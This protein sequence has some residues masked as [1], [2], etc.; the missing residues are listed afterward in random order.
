MQ[1]GDVCRGNMAGAG[2]S[3]LTWK[4]SLP[5]SWVK[6]AA[7]FMLINPP[8]GS[9]VLMCCKNPMGTIHGDAEMG[10]WY[11]ANITLRIEFQDFPLHAR[12]RAFPS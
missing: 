12:P 7:T 2:D 4:P 6:S 11:L 3:F 5:F 1:K 10:G 8:L 9:H